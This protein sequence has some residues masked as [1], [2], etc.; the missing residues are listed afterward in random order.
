[1]TS[2][3]EQQDSGFFV[4]E[5]PWHDFGT[6]IPN[7][8]SI[9]EGIK[10]A[11]MDWE[12]RLDELYTPDGIK[13]KN[14]AA[15]REIEGEKQILGVVGEN[16]TPLQ[17]MDAFKWFEPFV[18]SKMVSLETA[19]TLFN[20]KKVFILAKLNQ[21]DLE[22]VKDDIVERY[23][24]LSNSHDG[25]SCVRVGFTP[26]RVVCNNTL[27][28]A[29]EDDASKLIRVRHTNKV[30]LNL[31]ELRSVMDLV[32]AN[33]MTTK[34]HFRLLAY[35]SINQED[36]KK[37]VNNVFSSRKLETI[38]DEYDEKNAIEIERKRLI[39]RIEEIHESDTAR[40]TMWGA[41]NSVSAYLQHYKG[42]EKT[43][44]ESRYNQLW[45]GEG[46]RINKK[47]LV[48]ALEFANKV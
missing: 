25:S 11:G 42:T 9:E 7:A 36:L 28:M 44:Q 19:G 29:E 22:I 17:N 21:D 13:V 14:K 40:G 30:N 27:K 3:F 38:I 23:I 10:L 34:E 8:P 37:Y 6:V 15:F 26:I 41:Y 12:V 2:G 18:Q 20:G 45:F 47:A 4:K 35:T 46:D 43:T 31:D 5:R 33:F 1:M 16:Y 24:L 48:K 39:A 32:N